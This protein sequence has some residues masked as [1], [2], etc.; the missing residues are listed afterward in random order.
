MRAWLAR[1][2][3]SATCGYSPCNVAATNDRHANL[4][5]VAVSPEQLPLP[6]DGWRQPAYIEAVDAFRRRPAA[7]YPSIENQSVPV[8]LRR[9]R[10]EI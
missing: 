3:R 5:P 10:H 1:D 7:P 9:V 2:P 4:L 6:P 8:E